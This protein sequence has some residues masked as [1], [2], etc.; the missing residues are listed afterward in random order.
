MQR[1]QADAPHDERPT[2]AGFTAC[3]E[4]LQPVGTVVEFYDDF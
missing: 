4:P 3:A 2:V 1:L